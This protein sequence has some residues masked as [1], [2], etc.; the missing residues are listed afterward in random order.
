MKTY[1]IT[2]V[3]TI[4]DD[5]S[6]DEIIELLLDHCVNEGW[7]NDGIIIK[8]SEDEPDEINEE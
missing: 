4:D 5:I 8:E 6:D 2:M 7:E 3:I 1:T